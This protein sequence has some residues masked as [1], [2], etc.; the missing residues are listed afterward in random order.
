M[1]K[2]GTQYGG[3]TLPSNLD[4]GKESILYSAGVGEDISFDI[5]MSSYYDPHIVLIDPTQ[6]AVKH[7]DE[8]QQYYTANKEFTGNIQSDYLDKI[9]GH[10]PNFGKIIYENIGLW[11]EQGILQFYKQ[12]NPNYVSQTLIQGMYGDAYENVP[13]DTLQN[14]MKK[15]GHTSIDLL[16]LDIEGA[17]I[18]VLTQMLVDKIYPRYLC[19]EFDLWLKGK[20]VYGHTHR[21]LQKLSDAGYKILFEESGNVTFQRQS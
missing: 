7:W 15:H 1:K 11:K 2:Y 14:I 4:L 16:K 8:V 6:K 21:I 5:L 17:E 19:V 20:D 9:S 18:E 10:T 12:T 3:W 13:V